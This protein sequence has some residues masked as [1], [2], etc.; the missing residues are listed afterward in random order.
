[1]H[2]KLLPVLFFLLTVTWAKAQQQDSKTLQAT[3]QNFVKQGDYANAVL[4]LNRARQQDP[5]NTDVIKDLAYAQ[6]LQEDYNKAEETIKPLLDNRSA[7]VQTFQVAGLIYKAK[8]NE[9]EAEKVYR[10]ALKKFPSSG[11]LYNEYGNMLLDLKNNNAIRIWEKGIEVDPNYAGNYYNAAQYY[12]T[13]GDKIWSLLYAEIFVNMESYSKRTIDVKNLLL[14]T[15]RKL[16]TDIDLTKNAD[17]K[18]EFVTAYLNTLNKQSALASLGVTPE[19]LTMI[20]TRFVLTW[21]KTYASRF[22]YRLFEYHRQL[23]REGLFDAYNQWLFGPVQNLTAYQNW[24]STHADTYKEFT[25]FQRG[26]VFKLP[27]GQSYQSKQ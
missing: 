8:D 1:M 2:R 19:S 10:K 6:Y 24:T 7:D 21:D 9:G 16:F 4:V 27:T 25:D 18:G 26:R 5:E 3:A 11:I 12:S 17:G 22:P 13:A 15:Y 20:R 23:L 14:D